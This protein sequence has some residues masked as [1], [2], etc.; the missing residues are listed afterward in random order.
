[1]G[2]FLNRF[3]LFGLLLLTSLSAYSDETDFYID[4][5]NLRYPT[6]EIQFKETKGDSLVHYKQ[7]IGNRGRLVVNFWF[8]HDQRSIDHFEL[9]LDVKA[10]SILWNDSSQSLSLTYSVPTMTSSIGSHVGITVIAQKSQKQRY[11]WQRAE[12]FLSDTVSSIWIPKESY[13][14]LKQQIQNNQI[15]ETTIS[16]TAN[17]I[18]QRNERASCEVVLQTELDFIQPSFSQCQVVPNPVT[19]ISMIDSR[20]KNLTNQWFDYVVAKNRQAC[21]IPRAL[22][23]DLWIENKIIFNT[24]LY[25]NLEAKPLGDEPQV[26][27]VGDLIWLEDQLKTVEV[28]DD[29]M[30]S[31]LSYQKYSQSVLRYVD[32][33]QKNLDLLISKKPFRDFLVSELIRSIVTKQFKTRSQFADWCQGMYNSAEIADSC[34]QY[35]ADISVR[36]FDIYGFKDLVEFNRSIEAY[37]VNYTK[38][39]DRAM[40][41]QEG[42]RSKAYIIEWAAA[43]SESLFEKPHCAT[44]TLFPFGNIMLNAPD[45]SQPPAFG[46]FLYPDDKAYQEHIGQMAKSK[47]AFVQEIWQQLSDR[48]ARQTSSS[49]CVQHLLEDESFSNILSRVE[50]FP[51]D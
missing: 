36:F 12:N 26:M 21:E 49:I 10:L 23:Q 40:G 45:S 39:S 41:V 44:E 27:A 18:R 25:E 33:N 19:G 32:E 47:E 38:W 37:R 13:R 1:V 3:V 11:T 7:V 43:F 42:K 9:D 15:S 31:F 29:V 14:L 30:T 16:Q 35:A 46:S 28:S 34:F 2:L 24:R 22:S 8:E 5:L 50:Y 6:I 20:C 17:G 48:G 51:Y 4:V